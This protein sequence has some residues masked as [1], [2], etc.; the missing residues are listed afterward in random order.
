MIR[1]ALLF[2]LFAACTLPIAAYASEPNRD[3][4]VFGQSQENTDVG[5]LVPDRDARG[6]FALQ[7]NPKAHPGG[8]MLWFGYTYSQ[9]PG[10]FRA[11]FRLKVSDNTS[12]K[13]VATIRGDIANNNMID[14]EA[15]WF[16]KDIKGTDFKRPNV[17]QDFPMDRAKGESG[18]GDWAV[19][20][21]GVTTLSFGSLTVQQ[22]SHF[23]LAELLSRMH[24]PEKPFGLTLAANGGVHEVIGLYADL[25]GV[26][27]G[28][29]Q[30][31]KSFVSYGPQ[32]M[33]LTGFPKDW[34]DIYANRAIVLDNVNASAV[35]LVRC[36][37]LKQFVQ[38]GGCLLLMGDTHGV[39]GGDWADTPLEPLLP[40]IGLNS[41]KLIRAASPLPLEPVSGAFAGL[42]WSAQPYTL[43]YH[44]AAL[45]PGAEILLTAGGH[46]I[47]VR[48]ASGKGRVI[49]LLNS[50][51][52]VKS[53]GAAGLP[54]WEWPDWPK[55][56][57]RLLAAP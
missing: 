29:S 9:A 45:R 15:S 11:F 16:A 31:T 40:V 34:P 10:R 35:T 43:Y 33:G 26:A 27:P 28:A 47:A 42:D 5:V 7:H 4:I 57:A 8:G 55:V 30:Y 14:P 32:N 6:G 41:G 13:T 20:T 37:M 24:I 22:L 53:A 2:L 23:T 39:S 52:G 17:Y 3:D 54:W 50:V 44:D 1:I 38:D 12:P 21:T 49:V 36:M 56:M 51:L 19:M 48:L 18:F 46:P 25:W